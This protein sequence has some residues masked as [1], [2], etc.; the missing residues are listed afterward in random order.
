MPHPSSTRRRCRFGSGLFALAATVLAIAACGGSAGDATPT[1]TTINPPSTTAPTTTSSTSSPETTVPRLTEDDLRTAALQASD[2]PAGFLATTDLEPAVYVTDP[3]EC[4]HELGP[5]HAGPINDEVRRDAHH[6]SGLLG[7]THS[8]TSYA[9][10]QGADLDRLRAAF[11]GPCAADFTS[12]YG[13]ITA[14]HRFAPLPDPD[15]G[16]DA[17]AAALTITYVYDGYDATTSVVLVGV[18]RG[19]T[20]SVLQLASTDIPGAGHFGD[21]ATIDAVI[22][23]ARQIDDR[24]VALLHK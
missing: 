23:V 18:Q 2:L 1:E 20:W 6:E 24:V 7:Y 17:L 3:V 4:G 5:E 21:G 15:L 13:D 11:A 16:D 19:P 9:T 14:V 12:P 8:I 22:E 10:G